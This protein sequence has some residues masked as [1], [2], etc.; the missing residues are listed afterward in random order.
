M[1]PSDPCRGLLQEER[2]L[3]AKSRTVEPSGAVTL[4]Q[5]IKDIRARM[6]KIPELN[7]LMAIR[8]GSPATLQ[9]LSNI[10]NS[11]PKQK[12]YYVN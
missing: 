10:S 2:E 6:S 4:R 3:I 1:G 8:R 9:D 12:V 7:Q 11:I 5:Q